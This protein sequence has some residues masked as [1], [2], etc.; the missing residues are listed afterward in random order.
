MSQF[1]G[2]KEAKVLG[3]EMW[4]VWIR[5]IKI[6]QCYSRAEAVSYVKRLDNKMRS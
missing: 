4:Q 6:K 5:G 2:I 3:L 1:T